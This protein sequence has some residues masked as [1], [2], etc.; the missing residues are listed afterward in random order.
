MPEVFV[1]ICDVWIFIGFIF[2]TLTGILIPIILWKRWAKK[3]KAK[4]EKNGLKYYHS[5]Q[6][7][8]L[9]HIMYNHETR[10]YL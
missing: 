3:E 4:D 10:L 7:Y 2:V 1:T 8:L 6:V 9:I 5:Y